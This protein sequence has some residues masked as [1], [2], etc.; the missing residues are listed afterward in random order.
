[1]KDLYIG[2]VHYP[3][4]NK[5]KEIVVSAI[6]N[7]DIHDIAR[8]SKTF[9]A[10]KYFLITPSI[11]QQEIAKQVAE[12]WKTGYGAT[13]NEDRK[14]AIDLVVLT[15]DIQESIDLIIKETNKN[16]LVFATSANKGKDVLSVDELKEKVKIEDVPL[17]LLFGTGHGLVLDLIPQLNGM[18]EPISGAGD[19]NHLSVRSAASIYL[20]NLS[21][22]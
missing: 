22:N 5:N 20:Y 11:A 15:N 2:L 13:Y 9:G 17:L 16:P 18:L 1:M 10:K 6:T 4:S 8:A 14:D 12:H 7:L 19:Y 21:R 3:V